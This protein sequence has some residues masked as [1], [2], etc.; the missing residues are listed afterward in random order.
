MKKI[1]I[2]ATFL[3]SIGVLAACASDI[4]IT[5]N[6]HG[7]THE[8]RTI[9]EPGTVGLPVPGLSGYHFM[10]WYHD[11]DFNEPFDP[12]THVEEDL[13]LY[14]R[15][16]VHESYD[17]TPIADTVRLDP[18][19]YEGKSFPDDGI[20]EVTYEGCIDGDTTRFRPIDGQNTLSYRYLFIDA[21]EATSSV[22][23]W[24]PY[25]TDYVCSVLEN[26]E[27]IVIQY[28]PHPEHGLP[29]VHPSI[30]RTGTF[31]R[32]LVTV[33][34]DGRN[35]NLEL[36]ELGLSYTSGTTNSEFSRE[37][38]LAQNNADANGRRMW[39][40]DDPL[41]T[42]DPIEVSIAELLD[43]PDAYHNK[44]VTLEATIT[45]RNGNYYLCQDGEE[46]YLYMATAPPFMGR[47][48]G[49]LVDF[50]WLFFTDYF[51]TLQFT[52]FDVGNAEVIAEESPDEA[53][54]VD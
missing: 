7:E 13:T 18:S 28:E 1:F 39:G 30:G 6:V 8:V 51:G 23:P 46:L 53:C 44:F 43:D 32:D 21:P 41:F 36:V 15:T 38:Q 17:E 5:F 45:Y 2:L 42:S 37:Y 22:E 3:L 50:Q 19:D 25:A 4:E 48:I 47:N 24:G 52:G 54:L 40:Q 11:E 26:A 9:E 35:L 16:L 29:E 31:G 33:W 27:T 34:A 20:G 14:A 49:A 12:D 10:G